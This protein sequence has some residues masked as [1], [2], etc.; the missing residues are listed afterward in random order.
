FLQNSFNFDENLLNK[1]APNRWAHWG[2]WNSF[3]PT[4]FPVHDF[5]L[6]LQKSILEFLFYP[7]RLKRVIDN[8]VRTKDKNPFTLSELFENVTN[9]IFEEVLKDEIIIINS[10]RRNLQRAYVEKLGEVLLSEKYPNDAKSL[11]RYELTKVKDKIEK[12]IDKIEDLDT[13]AHLIELKEKIK[14]FLESS[15]TIEVKY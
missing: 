12:K 7:E 4:D 2:M 13:K 10:F 5:V 1:L 6:F 9:S 8:V 15:L 11:S 3:Y 14:K